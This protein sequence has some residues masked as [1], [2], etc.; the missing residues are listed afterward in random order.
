M[1]NLNRNLAEN[2]KKLR[3]EKGMTQTDLAVELGVL[4]LLT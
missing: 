1:E 3:K 4:F 2:I